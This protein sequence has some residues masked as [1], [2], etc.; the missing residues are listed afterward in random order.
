M[1]SDNSLWWCSAK[2]MVEM[3]SAHLSPHHSSLLEDLVV[4]EGLVDL[5]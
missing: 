4:P 2:A 1:L 5:D 3:L